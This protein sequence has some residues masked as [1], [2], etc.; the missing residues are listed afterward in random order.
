MIDVARFAISIAI[1]I[2]SVQYHVTIWGGP[3]VTFC[4]HIYCVKHVRSPAHPHPTFQDMEVIATL[5]PMVET[6]SNATVPGTPAPE[7]ASQLEPARPAIVRAV[8]GAAV[9]I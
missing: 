4:G 9:P 2:A 6:L 7:P 5:A 3:I 8:L 1:Y